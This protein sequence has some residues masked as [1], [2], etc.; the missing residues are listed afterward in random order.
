[1]FSISDLQEGCVYGANLFY[2]NTTLLHVKYKS[3]KYVKTT[4]WEGLKDSLLSFHED[5]ETSSPATPQ[6]TSNVSSTS[7]KRRKY[8][9][10]DDAFEAISSTSTQESVPVTAT[11]FARVEAELASYKAIIY[12]KNNPKHKDDQLQFWQD[13]QHQYPLMYEY[14]LVVLSVQ[15]SEAEAERLFSISGRVLIPSRSGLIN[16]CFFNRLR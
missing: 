8:I 14:A 13:N 3:N 9:D 16:A 6:P 4:W 1:M 10:L 15:A 5:V 7:A 2:Q 11:L 12:D